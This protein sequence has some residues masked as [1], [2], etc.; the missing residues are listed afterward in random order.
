[1]SDPAARL[2]RDA[3]FASALMMAWQVSSK[4]IRDSLFLTAFDAR[5]L[6]AMAGS[7]A[8]CAVLFAVLSAK[9]LHKYGPFRVIPVGYLLSV[10]LHG[11]EWMLLPAF[12][13]P[14]SALI[15]L[16][17]VA[18]GSVL[19]SGFWALANEAFDPLEARQKFGRIAAYGTLG[20]IGGGLVVGEVAA[21][22]SNTA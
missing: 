17:V 18:L 5:A 21:F 20:A 3:A 13:R 14:V 19:L 15:Y 6:P 7:A 12:P 11:A 8:V 9:I 2:A 4:T 22:F 16:H 10:G 1:M